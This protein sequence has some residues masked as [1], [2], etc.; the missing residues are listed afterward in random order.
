MLIWCFWFDSGLLKLSLQKRQ[1][2]EYIQHQP[3]AIFGTKD[4]LDEIIAQNKEIN[5]LLKIIT[6][7][8]KQISGD[9]DDIKI[10]T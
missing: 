8:K 7:D 10:K 5:R 2:V 4:K 9:F 3:F 1:F 6:E